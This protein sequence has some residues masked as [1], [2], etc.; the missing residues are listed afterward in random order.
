M[1]L[2]LGRGPFP[3]RET[4]KPLVFLAQVPYGKSLSLHA[5]PGAHHRMDGQVTQGQQMVK[6]PAQGGE[7][8]SLGAIPLPLLIFLSSRKIHSWAGYIRT[9]KHCWRRGSSHA[10]TWP[11]WGL[12]TFPM[13]SSGSMDYNGI[14]HNWKSESKVKLVSYVPG[15]LLMAFPKSKRR[16]SSCSSG[17]FLSHVANTEPSLPGSPGV[18]KSEERAVALEDLLDHFCA[19]GGE[20]ARI[21]LP[22]GRGDKRTQKR[23]KEVVWNGVFPG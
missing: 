14:Q 19:V 10:D 9:W 3:G 16:S 7:G 13:S 12:K 4:K 2:S 17:L 20:V 8:L 15:L 6:T 22:D 21:A 11:G 1:F 5:H 18:E 23:L